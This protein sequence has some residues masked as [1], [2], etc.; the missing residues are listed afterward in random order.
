M[1]KAFLFGDTKS[2][3]GVLTDPSADAKRREAPAVIFLNAGLVHRIGPNRLYVNLAR[4]MAA[5]GFTAFRFDL[6]GIGDSRARRDQLRL[7][8]RALVEAQAAMDSINK[9]RGI[10]K[11]VLVGLC[12][13][14]DDAIRIAS[15]DSRVVG[16]VLID[17]YSAVSRGFYLHSYGRRLLSFR[18]WIDLLTGRSFVWTL[19]KQRLGATEAAADAAPSQDWDFLPKEEMLSS[20]SSLVAR[21]ARL[22]FVYSGGSPALYNYGKDLKAE[23]AQLAADG[24]VQVQV[25]ENS[26]HIFTRLAHQ[27]LLSETIQQW[28]ELLI[29]ETDAPSAHHADGG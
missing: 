7:G 19:L 27:R 14:A 28:G 13:G 12:S 5:S 2:L 6:S 22:L 17:G 21:G 1:E 29:G 15:Q 23:F 11:F 10:D 18:S 24:R 20:V 8:E 16:M 9:S 26:D 4:A 3:V 25:F